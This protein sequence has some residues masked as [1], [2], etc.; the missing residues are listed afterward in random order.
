MRVGTIIWKKSTVLWLL[1]LAIMAGFQWWRGARVDGVLFTAVVIILVIDLLNGSPAEPQLRRLI[2]PRGVV[3]ACATI[4]GITLTFTPRNSWFDLIAVIIAGAGVMLLTWTPPTNRE[5]RPDHAV[6]RSATLW[7]IMALTLCVWEA[8]ALVFSATSALEATIALQAFPTVSVLLD[9][10][11]ESW[12]GHVF[13]V[14]CW[15][16]AGLGLL[17]L[18]RQP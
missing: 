16:L 1:T 7:A 12:I 8:L 10:F 9:P 17:R 15:L 6:R 14:A 13:F 18:Q 2:L 3:V 4:V 11:L 5:L